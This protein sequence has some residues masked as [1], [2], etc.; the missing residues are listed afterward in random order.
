MCGLLAVALSGCARN[1]R[2]ESIPGT[3]AG[4]AEVG[5]AG[6][7][8]LYL[9][10]PLVI[11]LVIAALVWLPG[12]VRSSRYRPGAG[13]SAPP[14]WFEGPPDPAAAVEGA[15]TGELNRGG[16]SGSW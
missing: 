9:L 7:V 16:A 5:A 11:A 1:E 12:M 8:V 6:A 4:A 14:V 13:W 3:D 10:V 2:V 15:D